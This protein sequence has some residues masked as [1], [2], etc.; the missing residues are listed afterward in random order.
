MKAAYTLTD[1]PPTVRVTC[2]YCRRRGRYDRDRLIAEYGPNMKTPAFLKAVS[3][4]C[5]FRPPLSTTKVCG[6]QYEDPIDRTRH[7]FWGM[8]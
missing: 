3:A 4:D 7:E 5:N 2:I 1:L 8:K 6:V